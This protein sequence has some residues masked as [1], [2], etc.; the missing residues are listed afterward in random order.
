MPTDMPA[1]YAEFKVD[2]LT[3]QERDSQGVY[4]VLW[5]ADSRWPDLPVST[6]LALAERVVSDLL[7][8]G[9]VTLVRG[10]WIGPEFDRQPVL[11]P[12][13]VLRDW[14]TWALAPDE[15]VV[16]MASN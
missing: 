14:A 16:W 13:A 6:R 1:D 12:E 10:K 3:D 8:E 2:V 5:S 11:D 7:H 4:E 9:R 15:P